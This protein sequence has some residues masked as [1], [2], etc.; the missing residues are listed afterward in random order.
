MVQRIFLAIAGQASGWTKGDAL[1]PVGV[2]QIIKMADD[3]RQTGHVPAVILT[4]GIF[5][6][7]QSAHI[8][9][10]VLGVFNIIYDERLTFSSF[11]AKSE[12]RRRSDPDRFREHFRSPQSAAEFVRETYTLK[13]E[14]ETVTFMT[15]HGW[16]DTFGKQTPWPCSSLECFDIVSQ[17][18]QFI[19]FHGTPI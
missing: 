4:D 17:S 11:C 14:D 6:A 12:R 7:V 9:G 5:S 1:N 13:P 2:E 8:L 19:S 16:G 10:G 18:Q 3:I 15:G